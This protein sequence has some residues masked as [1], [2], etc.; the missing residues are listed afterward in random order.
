[1][2]R[3]IRVPTVSAA[4]VLYAEAVLTADNLDDLL[5]EPE[6][7]WEVSEELVKNVNRFIN[8]YNSLFDLK[9]PAAKPEN[10]KLF[11]QAYRENNLEGRCVCI[12]TDI[13]SMQTRYY[14]WK[15]DRSPDGNLTAKDFWSEELWTTERYHESLQD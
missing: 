3:S 7:K 15:I 14:H 13:Q 8:E 4:L 2:R 1:M 6:Y 10:A 12:G 11:F 9:L 5:R